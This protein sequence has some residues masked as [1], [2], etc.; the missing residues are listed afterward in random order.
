MWFLWAF[1]LINYFY[2]LLSSVYN[3]SFFFFFKIFCKKWHYHG[4]NKYMQYTI[5]VP[6]PLLGTTFQVAWIFLSPSDSTL[7][8]IVPGYGLPWKRPLQNKQTETAIIP[9]RGRARSLH[10]HWRRHF[11]MCHRPCTLPKSTPNLY[12]CCYN[13]DCN[14][15]G[16][17]FQLR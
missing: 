4:P 1:Q 17:D 11:L 9:V 10:I 7:S 8:G 15:L 5:A 12:F 14:S 16:K 13:S 2:N 3:V 6:H